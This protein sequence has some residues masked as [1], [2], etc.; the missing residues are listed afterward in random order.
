MVGCAVT[1]S[2]EGTDFDP[3]VSLKKLF[4]YKIFPEIAYLVGRGGQYYGNTP[5]IKGYNSVPHE[6]RGYIQFLKNNCE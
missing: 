5:F 2:S 4:Q 1:G 6:E 3:K